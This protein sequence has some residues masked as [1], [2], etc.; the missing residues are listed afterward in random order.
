RSTSKAGGGSADSRSCRTSHRPLSPSA[1]ASRGSSPHPARHQPL[2]RPEARKA[3]TR[4]AGPF[5]GGNPRLGED[6]AADAHN[7]KDRTAFPAD[8]AGLIRT[9]LALPQNPDIR[10]L[11]HEA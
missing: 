3:K 7:G 2:S 10:D 11:Y 5:G 1:A 9:S 8:R 4:L 6:R